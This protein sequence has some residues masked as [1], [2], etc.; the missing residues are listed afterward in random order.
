MISEKQG[1]TMRKIFLV[2]LIF[3]LIA[4]L[5]PASVFGAG[6]DEA[7]A[8]GVAYRGHVEDYGDYPTDGSWVSEAKNLGTTGEG[9]RIE[10]FWIKLV[11]TDQLPAGAS[12]RYNVHVQNQGW[13]SDTGLDTAINWIG[14]GGFA[15]SQGKVQ[16]VE[17]IQIILLGEDGK[18]LPGYTVSYSVHGQDYGWSQG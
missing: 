9:K 15:G 17:A 4:I 12:I 3:A 14:D 11:G 13:L 1:K 18:Q 5:M 10:G 16:R 8:L 7:S 2:S 6:S